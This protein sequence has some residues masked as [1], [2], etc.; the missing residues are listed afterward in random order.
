MKTA[1]FILGYTYALWIMFLCVMAL[2]WKWET[3][4]KFL[5]AIA[6]PAILIAVILDIVFN[7]AV[8]VVFLELPKEITFSQRMG[9]YKYGDGIKQ[10][11]AVWVCGNFLDPFQIGGHCK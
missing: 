5:R 4:P 8:S 1:A 11:I 3:L 6:L 9:R 7:I 10:K 2:R